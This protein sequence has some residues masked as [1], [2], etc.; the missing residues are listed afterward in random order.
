M[1]RQR[2]IQQK[3][4]MGVVTGMTEA[5]MPNIVSGGG[6]VRAQG[7]E[8]WKEGPSQKN[9]KGQNLWSNYYQ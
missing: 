8:C 4:T 7:V 2:N 6:L 1:R 3:M 5:T 9:Q